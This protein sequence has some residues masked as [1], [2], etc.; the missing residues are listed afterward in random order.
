MRNLHRTVIAFLCA[1]LFITLPPLN[2]YS[3][4]LTPQTAAAISNGLST[5]PAPEDKYK[6]VAENSLFIGD[7]LTHGLSMHGRMAEPMFL[8]STG[9]NIFRARTGTFNT[10]H[11]DQKT[12]ASA[13][14]AKEYEAVYILFGIN[15]IGFNP[16]VF[17]DSYSEFI[18]YVRDLL[19][20]ARIYIMSVLPVSRGRDAAGVFTRARVN[21]F[22]ERLKALAE[23]KDGC[24]FIDINSKLADANGFLPDSST[25]DGVHLNANE[26]VVWAEHLKS[27]TFD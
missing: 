15:E 20:G 18:D 1:V 3:S 10:Q 8:Y 2:A 25:W 14:A 16:N 19:P 9:S 24:C 12:V 23:E 21:T 22:N 6:F 27:Y 13:V 17:I 26:Y 4:T 7:S 5:E 11:G